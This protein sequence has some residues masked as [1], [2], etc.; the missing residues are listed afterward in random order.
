MRCFV[1]FY[2]A[3]LSRKSLLWA[4]LAMAPLYALGCGEEQTCTLELRYAVTV[5]VMD[6][7]GQALSSEQADVFYSLDG[8]DPVACEG[9]GDGWQCGTKEG[10]Y[11]ITAMDIEGDTATTNVEVG[12]T[13]DGCHPRTQSVTLQLGPAGS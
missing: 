12:E 8:A 11:T 13:S 5:S 1:T 10:A 6:R 7:G 9:L 4:L 3:V 2:L